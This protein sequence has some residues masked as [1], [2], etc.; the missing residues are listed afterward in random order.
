M[1][2]VLVALVLSL[3]LAGVA[4]RW[5]KFSDPA[6]TLGVAGLIGLG[7]TSTVTFFLCLLTIH[8]IWLA[9]GL[10]LFGL[11]FGGKSLLGHLRFNRPESQAY[12]WLV[13]LILI[14][15][16]AWVGA[17]APPDMIEWDSLAYHLALPKIWFGAGKV[18]PVSFIHHSN[19]PGSVDG[20][21][22]IGL[23]LAEPV[24]KGINVAF[25][26][27]GTSAIFGAT[28]SLYGP[29]AAGLAALAFAVTP[30]VAWE[31]GTA[32]VDMAHGLFAGIGAF[33]LIKAASRHDFA[34]GGI[35][36]G[37]AV[38]SK[39]TGVL[40]AAIAAVI[41]LA[42]L[43]REKQNY[44]FWGLSALLCV[45]VGGGWYVKN[46]AWTGNPVY[47]FFYGVF[48][49]QNWSKF[50]ADIYA[51][52]QQTFGVPKSGVD[53]LGHGI[54]GLAYQPGRYNNPAPALNTDVSP[55]QG[56]QGMPIAAMGAFLFL[57]AL[58]WGLSGAA[59]TSERRLLLWSLLMLLSWWAL[60]QQS[61][62]IVSV[63]PILAILAGGAL[64]RL[65]A[66]PIL[67]VVLTL[68]LAYTLYLMKTFRFDGQAP[69]AFGRISRQEFLEA[70]VGLARN[71]ATVNE[72]AG[73][74]RVALYDEVF[75]Y[76]LDVRYFWA[77]P[78][79]G[80]ELD[81][82]KYADGNALCA[83]F[84]EMDFSHVYVNLT[85]GGPASQRLVEAIRPGGTPYTAE[86]KA[87]AM[88]PRS[89]WRW[90][91]AD[92]LNNGDL[93]VMPLPLSGAVM[94]EWANP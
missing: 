48:G 57:A 68:Q 56:A 25:L 8:A 37:L 93:K 3:G 82:E 2:W 55:P 59:G 6:L 10:A 76:L 21:F 65:R 16:M 41:A 86:E 80:V 7:L 18:Q 79:H 43:F 46:V 23:K 27:F 91:L 1:L 81:Y 61:R 40:P 32:Y 83:R 51:D 85:L 69:V 38:G 30:T 12:L 19:F 66:A 9:Y 33:V 15:F 92:A 60:S 54:L 52:E 14:I 64:V 26:L 31:T 88:D 75:G 77:N 71:A 45:A 63:A 36:L 58:A 50:N 49:G 44:K 5:V 62:Y 53:A 90:L 4:L 17:A 87:A 94:F 70:R 22:L 84:R 24:A 34:V 42:V 78:G 11:V 47:P 67:G 74:G 29:R 28:R 89:K 35:L 72:V 73:K 13:P 20:L 39:Y